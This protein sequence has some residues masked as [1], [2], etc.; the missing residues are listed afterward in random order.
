MWAATFLLL[1]LCRIAG[2]PRF[3]LSTIK[4]GSLKCFAHKVLWDNQISRRAPKRLGP[5]LTEMINWENLSQWKITSMFPYTSHVVPILGPFTS[6]IGAGGPGQFVFSGFSLLVVL[7]CLDVPPLK[8]AKK[9]ITCR[10]LSSSLSHTLP[11][12][13]TQI[14]HASFSPASLPLLAH[15]YQTCV[16]HIRARERQ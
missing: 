12:P 4:T 6:T 3:F 1:L 7:F 15:D 16:S 14:P 8:S 11:V 2:N 5:A 9:W 13:D 10:R